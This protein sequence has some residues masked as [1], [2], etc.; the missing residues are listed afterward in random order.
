MI[1][2]VLASVLS[3]WDLS[4]SYAPSFERWE[5]DPPTNACGCDDCECD[6]CKCTWDVAGSL[7]PVAPIRKGKRLETRRVYRGRV[8][9]PRCGPN[10]C[11][12]V[13]RDVYE[14]IQVEVT[15]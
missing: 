13:W 15:E 9:Y 5:L 8:G 7:A 4:M 10:G 14:D 12:T 1:I 2:L 11:Q 6:D 3:M